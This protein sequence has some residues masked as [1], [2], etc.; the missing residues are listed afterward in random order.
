MHTRLKRKNKQNDKYNQLVIIINRGTEAGNA[1]A[2]WDDGLWRHVNN[3]L[4]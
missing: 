3:M 4:L 2:T 1:T